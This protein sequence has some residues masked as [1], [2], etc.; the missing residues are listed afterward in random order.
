MSALVCVSPSVPNFIALVRDSVTSAHSKR[1]YERAVLKFMI[2]A[3]S[4]GTSF[5]KAAVQN[6]RSELVQRGLTASTVNLHISAIRKLVYEM[7]D[8]SLLSRDAAASIE[9][10]R[11]VERRG[12]RTGNWLTV[13]QAEALL[14]APDDA[15]LK[16]KRDCAVLAVLLGAGLRRSE[17]ASLTFGHIQEREGRWIIADICG[18]GGRVRT[19]PISSWTKAAVDTWRTAAGLS[20][21]HVFRSI[22]KAAIIIGDGLST[23][24]IFDVVKEYSTMIGVAIAPHDLRRTFA[25]LAHKGKAPLEQIQICLGHA[26][27]TTT[28]RY[29]G[30]RLDLHDAPCD[31]LG[32]TVPSGCSHDS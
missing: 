19:V 26:S 6:Y 23:Q 2:W 7:A 24:S 28:E 31:H 20:D 25:R 22:N 12:T 8:N 16:G 3:K 17:A 15:T 1:A 30:V 21:G 29:L 9:R 14:C 5:T 13:S 18:K 11:G 32:L 10:V 4:S 27:L